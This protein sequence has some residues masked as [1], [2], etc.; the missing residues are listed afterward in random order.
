MDEIDSRMVSEVPGIPPRVKI[1]KAELV[2]QLNERLIAKGMPIIQEVIPPTEFIRTG[3]KDI[4]E[5]TAPYDALGW[6]GF[7]RGHIT[8]VFGTAG[9]GKTSLM[10]SIV[11]FN[12]K[13]NVL[14]MDVE[15]GMTNPPEHVLVSKSTL[16]ENIEEIV[17]EAIDTNSYD[18]IIIDSVAMMSSLRE[19]LRDKQAMMEKAKAMG[20]FG[21]RVNAYLRDDNNPESSKT[22][23]IFVN[24]LRD[25]GNSFG[26]KEFTPGGRFLEF[27]ASL[28]LEL[29]S[30]KADK[31]VKA[32]ATIG[33]RVRVK[34]VKSRW[35]G[36]DVGTV[37]IFN[38]MFGDL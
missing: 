24:Q 11:N 33:Q 34:I 3:F 10:K 36:E 1:T 30:A 29:R 9:A 20:V 18:M 16:L 19:K 35:N 27:G 6:G 13:M 8:E 12:P 21:R 32:G 15:N 4:D 25:T 5:L 17:I 26:V 22:A 7:P 31:I 23:V 28:R 38:L 14:Y 37:V 2:L